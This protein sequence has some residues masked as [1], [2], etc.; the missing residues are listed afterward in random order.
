MLHFGLTGYARHNEVLSLPLRLLLN[1]KGKSLG[2]TLKWSIFSF[3]NRKVNNLHWLVEPCGVTVGK[4]EYLRNVYIFDNKS[5]LTG[6]SRDI[7]FL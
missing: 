1:M 2:S 5:L 4:Q 6:P 7:Y 3:C